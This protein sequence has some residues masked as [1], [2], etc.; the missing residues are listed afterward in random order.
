MNQMINCKKCSHNSSETIHGKSVFTIYKWHKAR[1]IKIRYI[2]NKIYCIL[3]N[4]NCTPPPP[5]NDSKGMRGRVRNPT[6]LKP[7]S[8]IFYI[9]IKFLQSII[10]PKKTQINEKKYEQTT[11]RKG[12]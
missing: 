11:H 2:K 7:N 12:S 1:L 10:I 4:K 5:R 8:L 6:I 3:K 9:Y